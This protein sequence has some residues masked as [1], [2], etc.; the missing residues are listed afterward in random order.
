M[1]PLSADLEA[2]LRRFTGF[3]A[4]RAVP[5][6][7]VAER[8]MARLWDRHV[9][10]SMR[11]VPLIAEDAADAVDI[12][13]GAGLPGI[14]VAAARPDLLVTLLEAQ[15]KRVAFLEYVI[16]EL[17]LSNVKVQH[18]RA[19]HA[20]IRA[21]VAFARAVG[22]AAVAWRLAQP[23]L[24]SGGSLLYFAGRS[25]SGNVPHGVEGAIVEWRDLGSTADVGPI[26]MISAGGG[27]V[28]SPT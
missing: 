25:W 12:G 6:G 19:E 27:S 4:E 17:S 18:G 3:L 21:D 22:P 14:V 16:G 13:S 9:L 24:R 8:D 5:Q 28:P 10:D 23:L 1:D 7:F 11:A 2:T 20:A 26:V 15:R